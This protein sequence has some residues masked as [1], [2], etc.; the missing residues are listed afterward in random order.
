MFV[1]PADGGTPRQ[2]TTGSLRHIGG[3]PAWAPDG[4][5]LLFRPI[6][7][8]TA[9]TIRSTPR[10]MSHA[11]R[12]RDQGAD[13]PQRPRHATRHFRRTATDR[14]HSVSTTSTR[15]TK[16]S[17]LHHEPRRHGPQALT[18][19]WTATCAA[20]VWSKDGAAC[21][22]SMTISGNT[23]IGFST[24]WTVKTDAPASCRRHHAG[25]SLRQRLLFGRR[26]RHC[27]LHAD[28]PGHPA[29]V[30]V[31]TPKDNNPPLTTSTRAC[32]SHKIGHGGRDSATSQRTMAG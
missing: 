4:K 20:P 21:T 19:S 5:A 17:A 23:R 29:E 8:P 12:W 15:A 30:A 11:R 7:I 25:S 14:L 28:Q 13:K 2:L 3:A 16:L 18:E 26:R 6:A 9:N 24:R 32:S 22:F 31:C 27:G 10:S 1:L